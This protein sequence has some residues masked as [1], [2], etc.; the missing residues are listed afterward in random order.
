MLKKP[1]R[2]TKTLI[3]LFLAFS[4][5]C[6]FIV[7]QTQEHKIMDGPTGTASAAAL[8]QSNISGPL[9]NTFYSMVPIMLTIIFVVIIIGAILMLKS[10]S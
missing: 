2:Y 6:L 1:I 3:S 5:L 4:V 10:R 8:N 9:N 7:P